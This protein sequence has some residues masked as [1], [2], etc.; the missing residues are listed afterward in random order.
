[1]KVLIIEDEIDLAKT[2]N[3]ALFHEG[4]TT[5]NAYTF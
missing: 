1:M 3:R 4:Y 2:I 5:E